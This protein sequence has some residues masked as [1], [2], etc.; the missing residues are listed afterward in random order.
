VAGYQD[1]DDATKAMY[2]GG[3]PLPETVRNM[4]KLTPEKFAAEVK[5][6]KALLGI[7]SPGWSPSPYHALCQGVPFINPVSRAA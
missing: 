5:E 7:G 3:L 1:E 2:E 6:S 4:G